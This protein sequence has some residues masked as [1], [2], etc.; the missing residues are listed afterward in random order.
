MKI[1]RRVLL[2]LATLAGIVTGAAL[3]QKGI[4]PEAAPVIAASTRPGKP[5]ASPYEIAVARRALEEK[6]KPA[7]EFAAFFDRLKRVFPPEYES[8]VAALA[9]RS[10]AGG[11]IGNADLLMA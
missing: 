3:L 1:L 2:G 6:L 10:A 5:W 4:R 11:E 7:P 8:F 9:Q